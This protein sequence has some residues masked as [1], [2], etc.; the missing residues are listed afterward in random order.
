MRE[1]ETVR[2][3]N[4]Y[5]EAYLDTLRDREEAIELETVRQ[6]SL[7][8]EAYLDILRDGEWSSKRI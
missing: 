1:L 4:L 7:Y 3:E 5:K 6:E 2:Q 8:E